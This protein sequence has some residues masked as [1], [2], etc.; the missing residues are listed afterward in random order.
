MGSGQDEEIG[1]LAV[2]KR[3]E[4]LV[5]CYEITFVENEFDIMSLVS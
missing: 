3:R 5:S 2:M 1:K 4:G